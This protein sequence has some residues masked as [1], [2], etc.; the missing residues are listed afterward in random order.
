MALLTEVLGNDPAVTLCSA[1]HASPLSGMTT[2][3]LLMSVFHTAPWVRLAR[4]G[5]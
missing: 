3:Y 1:A 4:G 5:A 2:M